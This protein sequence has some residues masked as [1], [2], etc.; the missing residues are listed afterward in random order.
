MLGCLAPR[1]AGSLLPARARPCWCGI[2]V[3]R[4]PLG[5]ARGGGLQ[6]GTARQVEGGA[7]VCGCKEVE[8]PFFRINPDIGGTGRGG[9]FDPVSTGAACVLGP[10]QALVDV[11]TAGGAG[12]CSKFG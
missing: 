12:F 10:C 9:R 6:G 2:A 4:P 11:A 5:L 3:G 1:A 7:F 8:H